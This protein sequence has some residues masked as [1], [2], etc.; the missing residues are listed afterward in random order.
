MMSWQSGPLIK[1]KQVGQDARVTPVSESSIRDPAVSLV[2]TY[3][4]GIKGQN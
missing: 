2:S 3:T 4:L 1:L